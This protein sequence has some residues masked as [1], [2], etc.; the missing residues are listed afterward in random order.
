[1]S[2]VTVVRRELIGIWPRIPHRGAWAKRMVEA[3]DFFGLGTGQPWS[4]GVT[5]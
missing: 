3:N 5:S 4:I 1:M 2:C